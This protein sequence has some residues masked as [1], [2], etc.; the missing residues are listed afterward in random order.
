MGF[1]TWFLSKEYA[2]KGLC[3]G[4]NYECLSGITNRKISSSFCNVILP[5]ECQFEQDCSSECSCRSGN[6]FPKTG[7]RPTKTVKVRKVNII[8]VIF[9]IIVL[10]ILPII[11]IYLHDDFHWKIS[12]LSYSILI[13]TLCLFPLIYIIYSYL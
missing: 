1:L 6:C 2:G 11:L 4:K 8:L 12:K 10:I 13:I 9:S 3:N 7:T 5:C